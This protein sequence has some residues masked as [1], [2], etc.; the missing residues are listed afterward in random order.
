MHK[1][2]I[3]AIIMTLGSWTNGGKITTLADYSI[4]N[5]YEK[6]DEMDL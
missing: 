2:N 4:D 3:R 5:I 1:S 6:L